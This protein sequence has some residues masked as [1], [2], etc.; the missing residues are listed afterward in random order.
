MEQKLFTNKVVLNAD[1]DKVKNV[2]NNPVNL[3]RWV[4][5]ISDVTN[6][7]DGFAITRTEK[8]INKNEVISVVNK[9]NEIEYQSVGD[10]I[11]YR[12]LFSLGNEN[13][14]CVIKEKV[15]VSEEL[16]IK[17]PFKLLKPIVKHAF[18]INLQHLAMFIEK[19]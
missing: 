11:K 17:L 16:G 9:D 5:E 10:K 7:A 13:E 2:L 14:Q 4:P 18:K 8:A 6:T 15:Y 3:I 1:I 19:N 12:I